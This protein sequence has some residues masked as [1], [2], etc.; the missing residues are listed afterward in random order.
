MMER[1]LL[2][3]G[4]LT[5][6]LTGAL[7][8][9]KLPSLE[10]VL[11]DKAR[12]AGGR[13]STSRSQGDPNCKVDLG[14]Q[15]ISV[16]PQY[17]QIHGHIFEELLGAGILKQMSCRVGGM[18]AMEEGTKHYVA[19]GGVSSIVKHFIAQAKLNPQF[20]KHITRVDRKDNQWCVET[21]SGEKDI[22]DVVVLTMPVPQ[23]LGLSGT[24]AKSINENKSLRHNLEEVKYSSR[25]ALGLFFDSGTHLSLKTDVDAQYITGDSIMRFV[26][27]DNQKR[28][29]NDDPPSVVFHTS[30]PFGI[31]H[32]DKTPQEVEPILVNRVKEMFPEWP[33][34]LSVK[35]QKWKFS[36]VSSAFTGV[37][38]CIK[39]A[40]G[41]LAGGDGF[42]H[43]NMDGC[44]ESANSIAN[45]VLQCSNT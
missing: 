43:S 33:Q 35:C 8:R 29:S 45:V 9:S 13:M 31:G 2:V 10:L 41:L 17:E 38:G 26:A 36:Q 7:L 14:C 44:I 4:G 30:V 15:Y 37:P 18:K 32:V 19:P 1:V 23:I 34:P 40:E 25:Y 20:G 3:G 27:I 42:T 6:A 39:I 11:W 24:V 21:Q 22:F 28:G 16:V 5:A 12:G